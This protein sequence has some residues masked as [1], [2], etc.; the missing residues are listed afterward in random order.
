[1]TYISFVIG[2]ACEN[3]YS[4]AWWISL[5]YIIVFSNKIWMHVCS[6]VLLLFINALQL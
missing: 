6:K 3:M 2:F 5:V 1:M 4:F